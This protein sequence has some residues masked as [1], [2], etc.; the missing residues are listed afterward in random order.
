MRRQPANLARLLSSCVVALLV[1]ACAAATVTTTDAPTRTSSPE[2]STQA[3]AVV[4]TPQPIGEPVAPEH[5]TEKA[6]VVRITDGDTIVVQLG[7]KNFKLR[8]IG[9]DSPELNS[10]DPGVQALARA[11][12]DANAALVAGKT[13]YLERDVSDKDTY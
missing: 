10:P 2:R 6:K 7:G 9:M 13:V 3:P 11:A 8:Y 5:G 12:A 4:S 1:A